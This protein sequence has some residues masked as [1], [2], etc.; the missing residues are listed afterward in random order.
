MFEDL[1]RQ[2]LWGGFLVI[3][4][5]GLALFAV[6]AVIVLIVKALS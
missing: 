1:Y 4:L 5:G 3:V 2:A 6:G